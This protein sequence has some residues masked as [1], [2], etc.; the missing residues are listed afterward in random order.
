MDELDYATDIR[1][2]TPNVD[3]A[4]IEGLIKHLGIALKGRDSS[5]VAC[6]EKSERDRIRDHFLKKKLALAHADAD[7]DQAII[8]ICRKMAK[9]PGQAARDVLLPACGEIRQAW[10]VCAIISPPAAG[11]RGKRRVHRDRP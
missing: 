3:A 9:R 11:S 1:K 6:S 10:R 4:S 8:D 7:L 5:L 2:Y